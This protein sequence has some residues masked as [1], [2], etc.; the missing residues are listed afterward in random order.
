MS[1]QARK[2]FPVVVTLLSI[3][4][5]VTML[6]LGFWQLDRKQQKEERLDQIELGAAS[7]ELAL[8]QAMSAPSK[9]EDFRVT[10]SGTADQNLF[11]VDN[12]LYEGRPGYHVLQPLRTDFGYLIVNLGWIYA[13][14]RG[15]IPS[16]TKLEGTVQLTGVLSIPTDNVFIK[17]TNTNYSQFPVILQQLDLA[18]IEKHLNVD[19]FPF[20]LLANP[21]SSSSFVREWKA[22]VMAPEKHL[23]YAI[24]WFGL[25]I[26]A[27]TVYLISIG[28]YYKKAGVVKN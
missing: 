28:N 17:E 15:S 4:S 25:A 11:Y 1:E 24:Q 10:V 26:A 18:E 12:K 16:V 21:E 8:E 5:I 9:Y 20:V 7:G 19:A 23:G 22:V 2:P 3:I 14:D 27:L 6:I 13:Q